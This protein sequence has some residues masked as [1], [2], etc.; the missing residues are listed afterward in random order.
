MEKK[1]HY[2][3]WTKTPLSVA[4]F[5]RYVIRAVGGF[6]RTTLVAVVRSSCELNLCREC[7][8]AHQIYAVGKH[9]VVALDY[10][11]RN[12]CLSICEDW[13]NVPNM[14]CRFN[15]F[16]RITIPSVVTTVNL[17]LIGHVK[18]SI[19]SWRWELVQIV[20]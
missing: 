17:T 11:P 7:R 9:E 18:I 10:V 4:R 15:L 20:P 8:Q 19:E 2:V 6:K 12:T 14:I 16:A 1:N 5:R 3:T 13:I